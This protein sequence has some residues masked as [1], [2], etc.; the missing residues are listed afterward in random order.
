MCCSMS[1]ATVQCAEVR[2]LAALMLHLAPHP[3]RLLSSDLASAL[4]ITPRIIGSGLRIWRL[5]FLSIM[6][7]LG[8]CG[9]MIYVADTALIIIKSLYHTQA[10]ASWLGAVNTPELETKVIRRFPKF[11]NQCFKTLLRYYAKQVLT[12]LCNWDADAKVIRDGR[13]G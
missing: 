8:C 5:N 9:S 3:G 6:F 4:V 2:P 11:H 13:D 1:N 12:P 7:K 10:T